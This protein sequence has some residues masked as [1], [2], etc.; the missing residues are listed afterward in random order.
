MSNINQYK[1][2]F[3]LH[4][5]LSFSNVSADVLCCKWDGCNSDANS[6]KL[7]R[8]DYEKYLLHQILGSEYDYFVP[9]SSDGENAETFAV[10]RGDGASNKDSYEITTH[11]SNGPTLGG[12]ENTSNRRI[13][14][15]ASGGISRPPSIKHSNKQNKNTFSSGF[16]H[17]FVPKLQVCSDK[18]IRIIMFSKSVEV[19]FVAAFLHDYQFLGCISITKTR[20]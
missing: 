20:N 12:G 1:I 14:I 9:S 13:G 3:I 2:S 6:A 8:V 17:Y 18:R 7:S 15:F 4:N 10:G 16:P 11:K 19:L 5:L